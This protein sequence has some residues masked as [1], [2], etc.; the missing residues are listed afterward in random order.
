MKQE[1]TSIHNYKERVLSIGIPEPLKE[2]HEDIQEDMDDNWYGYLNDPEIKEAFDIYFEK[3]DL[4]TT[5]KAKQSFDRYSKEFDEKKTAHVEA[6]KK[7][8][9]T[10]TSGGKKVKEVIKVAAPKQPKPARTPK[11]A[12][13]K[14]AAITKQPKATKFKTKV[15]K[16]SKIQ[17]VKPVKPLTAK[18]QAE[19]KAKKRVTLTQAVLFIRRFLLLVNKPIA[20]AKFESYLRSLQ[21]AITEKKIRKS[22]KFAEEVMYIQKEVITFCNKY[23]TEANNDSKVVTLALPDETLAKLM[24]I[25]GGFKIYPSLNIL[26][27]YLSIQGKKPDVK[28]VKA[29]VDK[30][31]KMLASK[32]EISLKDPFRDKVEKV[33]AALARILADKKGIDVPFLEPVEL[34]GLNGKNKNGKRGDKLVKLLAIIEKHSFTDG[35]GG[36]DDIGD[37]TGIDPSFTQRDGL[38]SATRRT[39]TAAEMAQQSINV[40]DTTGIYGKILGKFGAG[41]HL[42]IHGA[43]GQGKSSFALGLAKHWANKG[44]RV[45]YVSAEEFGS[46]TLVQKIQRLNIGTAPVNFAPSIRDLRLNQLDV[47]FIDSIQAAGLSIQDQAKLK[48]SYPD[49]TVVFIVQETKQG[50]YKGG[51]EWGHNVDAVM[52]FDNG[53]ARTEKNRFGALAE[54][55][56][57]FA[58]IA[59]SN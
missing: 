45:A 4:L 12:Q 51:S 10:K 41:G 35:L 5:E 14:K 1:K 26:K 31:S 15:A 28:K 48:K 46:P 53:S 54:W 11:V 20:F 6:D 32:Q 57:S 16:P 59:N 22:N 40:L 29:L 34:K 8:K 43:A 47:L 52:A 37:T 30:T 50:S 42:M 2:M 21:K 19:L 9:S 49:L 38:A 36:L 27:S 23:G 7:P 39:M 55:P 13:A 33:K 3:Y 18:Q 17:V 58:Q 44:Y 56:V 24:A 25:A